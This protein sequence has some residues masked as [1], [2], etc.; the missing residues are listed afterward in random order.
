MILARGEVNKNIIRFDKSVLKEVVL[1]CR[2]DPAFKQQVLELIAN[3][4]IS[5]GYNVDVFESHLSDSR[6]ELNIEKIEK[7]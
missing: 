4:Y 6:Y 7:W 2:I 3:E 5:K 1:G